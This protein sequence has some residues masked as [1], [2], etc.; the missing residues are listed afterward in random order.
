MLAG[1]T[2]RVAEGELLDVEAVARLGHLD[3][4]VERVAVDA[5]EHCAVAVSARGRAPP[6]EL[7]LD[8]GEG[9]ARGGGGAAREGAPE[10]CAGARRHALARVPRRTPPR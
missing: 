3:R 2:F 5:G 6:A 9:A 10:L 4:T 7:R 1:A 8:D